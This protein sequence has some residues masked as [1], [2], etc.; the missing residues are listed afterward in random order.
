MSPRPAGRLRS[1]VEVDRRS[2]S[3]PGGGSGGAS[4]PTPPASFTGAGAVSPLHV[5]WL[6]RVPYDEALAVQQALFEH[7]REQHL[8]LLEHPPVYTLGGPRP[9]TSWSTRPMSAP[10]SSGPTGAATSR[11]TGRASSWATPS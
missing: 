4:A 5:R 10:S 8:L 1:F 7:G 3:T 11:T 6:G 9:T 2:R